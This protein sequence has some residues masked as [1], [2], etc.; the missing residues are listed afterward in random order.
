MLFAIIYLG[1]CF[2]LA[3][4]AES[5]DGSFWVTFVISLICTPIAGFIVTLASQAG[6]RDFDNQ[7]RE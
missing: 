2:A 5:V 4:W 3:K 7:M 1:L 6:K